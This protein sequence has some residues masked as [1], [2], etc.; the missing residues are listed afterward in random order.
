ML[1]DDA[2]ITTSFMGVAISAVLFGAILAG[3]ACMCPNNTAL[4]LSVL[5]WPAGLLAIISA[6]ITAI[7]ASKNGATWSLKGFVAWWVL[8]ILSSGFTVAA[9]AVFDVAD[10]L[11]DNPY[12]IWNWRE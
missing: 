6:V 3:L 10:V 2:F 11:V 4:Y 12:L 9:I 1:D 7:S 5:V 8:A